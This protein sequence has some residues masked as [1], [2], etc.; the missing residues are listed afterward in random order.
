M[1]IDQASTKARP[2]TAQWLDAK[3]PTPNAGAKSETRRADEAEMD[4]DVK[5]TSHGFKQGDLV[6]LDGADVPPIPPPPPPGGGDDA[7]DNTG[8]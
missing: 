7:T 3:A 6:I 4:G 5:G 1:A 8:K 2:W